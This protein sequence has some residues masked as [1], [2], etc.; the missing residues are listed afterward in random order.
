[1]QGLF[2]EYKDPLFG[3]IIF[4]AIIFTVTLLTYLWNLYTLRFKS[5]HI[6]AFVESFQSTSRPQTIDNL[7][8]AKELPLDALLLLAQ[9][10]YKSSHYEI[11]IEICIDILKRPKNN[12][13]KEV[14]LLLAKS[15]YKAGFYKRSETALIELLRFNT[16]EPQALNYLCVIYERLH[17]FNDATDALGALNEM[18]EDVEISINYI[19]TIQILKS[20]QTEKKLENAKLL[21]LASTNKKLIRPIFM[22]LFR[23]QTSFAWKAFDFSNYEMIVDILWNLPKESLDFDIIAQHDTLQALWY[24]KGHHPQSAQSDIFEINVLNTLLAHGH[25]DA[26]L[27]FSYQCDNCKESTPL[28]SHRCPNCLSLLSL[29]T[30]ISVVEASKELSY[31]SF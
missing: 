2:L 21:E 28:M 17:R 30:Q 9:T 3:M 6:E 27:A 15:Y 18:G 5:N 12:L 13:Q 20:T 19:K 24:A 26:S 14:L 31:Y 29:E 11:T 22:H 16:Q 4:V 1:L 23:T 25:S 8:A 7:L 10:Y